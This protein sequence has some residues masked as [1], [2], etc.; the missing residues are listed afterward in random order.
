MA[1]IGKYAEASGNYLS[2]GGNGV[3]FNSQNQYSAS[4]NAKVQN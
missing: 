4:T 3:L 1:V 2:H